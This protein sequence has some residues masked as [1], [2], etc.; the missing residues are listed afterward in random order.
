ML[1]IVESCPCDQR[2]PHCKAKCDGPSGHSFIKT[3]A[4]GRGYAT[5]HSCRRHGVW[6]SGAEWIQIMRSESTESRREVLESVKGCAKC[7]A[8]VKRL[9]GQ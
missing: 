7:T 6:A 9:G 2:C 5:P 8:I 1:A 3:A 4:N